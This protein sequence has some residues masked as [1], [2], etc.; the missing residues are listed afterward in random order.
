MSDDTPSWPEVTSSGVIDRQ[1]KC[2]Q[3]G[4]PMMYRVIE[5][6]VAETFCANFECGACF[7]EIPE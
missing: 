5:N 2:A 6:R 3:C 4:E 7:V 1:D